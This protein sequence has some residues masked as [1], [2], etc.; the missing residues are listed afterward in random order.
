MLS[1]SQQLHEY[2]VAV[3]NDHDLPSKM[4]FGAQVVRCE[5]R[6]DTTRWR[7]TVRLNNG[8]HFL[9][10]SQFLF[11]ATG[12]LVTPR[13]PDLPGLDSFAG[14]VFH[15]ARWPP[16]LSLAGKDVALVGNGCT[17]AQI[18][19][20]IVAETRHLTQYM[21]SKHWII[22]PLAIPHR[23]INRLLPY[24]PGLLALMRFCVFLVAENDWRG[25]YMTRAGERFRKDRERSAIRYIRDTAPAKFHDKLTPDLPIGCKRRI[26]DPGYCRALHAPNFDLLDDP[27]AEVVPDGIRTRDGTLT[28]ADVIILANGY[29]TNEFMTG[30]DMVGRGGVTLAQHWQ[31]YDG[32]EAYNC[33]AL[34]DFPNFFMILGS[35]RRRLPPRPGRCMRVLTCWGPGPNTATGHTSTVMAMENA[36]NYALRIIKPVLDGDA[37]TAEVKPEAEAAYSRQMQSDLRKTVWWGGCSSWYKTAGRSGRMWNSMTYPHSQ[38]HYWYR[39]LFPVYDDW[40]Y[41]VCWPAAQG[42]VRAADGGF[43]PDEAGRHATALPAQGAQAGALDRPVGLGRRRRLVPAQKGPRCRETVAACGAGGVQGG[44]S[45]R[46]VL[47]APSGWGPCR[48]WEQ[49]G[50]DGGELRLRKHPCVCGGGGAAHWPREAVSRPCTLPCRCMSR[51][52]EHAPLTRQQSRNHMSR[53]SRQS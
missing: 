30:I 38:A 34:S 33:V 31:A 25:F 2:L 29:A 16:G 37:D 23:T 13:A 7:L 46:P 1:S 3:A 15:A 27:I 4:T 49:Q 11:G 32:P 48:E 22:P 17:A 47:R 41:T 14:T 36:I 12:L 43:V 28:K 18:V 51:G 39:C 26:Y 9:H 19:P 24:V 45:P 10:E 35:R 50:D 20:S 40:K 21:R 8:R 52:P 42:C 44:T 6:A 53:V 5:W